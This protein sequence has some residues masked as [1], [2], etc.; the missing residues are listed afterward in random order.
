MCNSFSK[1]ELV[2]FKKLN[3]HQPHDVF[4]I[5]KGLII[6]QCSFESSIYEAFWG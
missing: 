4:P 2:Q 3:H 6:A 1:V 5:V